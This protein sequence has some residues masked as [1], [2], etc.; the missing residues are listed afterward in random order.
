MFSEMGA[1]TAISAERGFSAIYVFRTADLRAHCSEKIV[2]GHLPEG[3]EFVVVKFDDLI[4]NGNDAPHSRAL[5]PAIFR[6][7]DPVTI[8]CGG[9]FYRI[10]KSMGMKPKEILLA[11]AQGGAPNCGLGWDIIRFGDEVKKHDHVHLKN[12]EDVLRMKRKFA[13]KA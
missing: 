10:S 13:K 9:D 8:G 3:E 11:M 1:L 5:L 12:M 7:F 2:V 6:N 4:N